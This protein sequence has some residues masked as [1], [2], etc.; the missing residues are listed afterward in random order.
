M[1]RIGFIVLPGFQIMNVAA[2]AGF[3]MADLPPGDPH[4]EIRLLSETGGAVRS[5]C[6]VAIDT[7]AFGDPD[8]DTII[9]GGVSG[10]EIATP[11]ATEIAFVRMASTASRRTASICSGAFVLAEAGLLAGHRATTHWFHAATFKARF[12][13]VRMEEDRIFINDGSIW[14]SA[15]M[16]AGTDL[17]LAMI[18]SDLGPAAAKSAARLLVMNQ[19]RL[20][21]QTQHS[22][23]LDMAPKSDRIAAVLAHIV[24]NLRNVLSVQEL[25][26]VAGLSPRQFSRA[27]LAET[28]QSPAR[29]VEH[30]RLEAAR[31]MLEEGRHPVDVIAR[32]A[33]FADRER[34][35]RAFIRAVG[36]PPLSLRR[37]APAEEL[38]RQ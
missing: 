15:G 33:G 12:P 5:S 29:A 22:A 31:F 37:T 8:F 32:E 1:H 16:T 27:F 24:S 21:G 19:R 30:L 7:E 23:L 9:V 4:Y 28:G 3:E 25:A 36:V 11:T 10:V 20:G 14:T 6:G 18:E 17:V 2:L 26:G 35:R 34:M 13:D 38:W